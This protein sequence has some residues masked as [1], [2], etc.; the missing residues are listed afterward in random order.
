MGE[1]TCSERGEDSK[2]IVQLSLAIVMDG[3]EVQGEDA[4]EE[5]PGDDEEVT[6][7]FINYRSLSA[8]NHDFGCSDIE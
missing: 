5:N 4:A 3:M 2:N 6:P 7:L 8:V 1:W